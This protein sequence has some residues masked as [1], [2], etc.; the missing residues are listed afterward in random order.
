VS[1]ERIVW[2]V[3]AIIEAT[4][5]EAE[6]AQKAI[7]RAL[8]PDEN[9]PGYCAT[10]WTMMSCRFEHLT[11]EERTAWQADFLRNEFAPERRA[12]REPDLPE[13]ADRGRTDGTEERGPAARRKR[14][15]RRR[16][17]SSIW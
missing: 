11:E 1:T 10:P 9:H 3:T 16:T 13:R 7:A 15:G 14:S 2:K 17:R 12:S 6:A 5:E 8:C 4:A